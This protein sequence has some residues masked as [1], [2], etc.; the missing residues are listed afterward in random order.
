MRRSCLTE[1]VFDRLFDRVFDSRLVDA[2]ELFNRLFA[3]SAIGC[4]VAH[5]KQRDE[6]SKVNSTN[7]LKIC[8]V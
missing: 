7:G 1:R 8:T 2:Q 3:R 4:P 6:A 5:M